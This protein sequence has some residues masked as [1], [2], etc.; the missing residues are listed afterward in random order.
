MIMMSPQV[1]VA[2]LPANSL[3]QAA[4]LQLPGGAHH[5]GGGIQLPASPASSGVPFSTYVDNFLSYL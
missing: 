1:Q 2:A 5:P 3:G 4:H